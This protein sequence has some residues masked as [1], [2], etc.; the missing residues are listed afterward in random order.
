[1]PTY[2]AYRVAETGLSP[3]DHH[4]IFI[5]THEDGPLTGHRFHVIGNIQEGMAFNHRACIK[6]EDEPVFLTKEKLGVVRVQDYESGLFL[7][8]CEEVEVP[9]KQFDGPRRLFPKEKLRRCQEW[10]DEAVELLVERGVL[11]KEV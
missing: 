3:R 7:R 8:V 1:M 6:P 9:K 2:T 11:V 10:A 4:Y 5:E